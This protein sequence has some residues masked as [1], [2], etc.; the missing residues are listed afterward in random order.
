MEA[1]IVLGNFIIMLLLLRWSRRV[2]RD[3][4]ES[5]K[6]GLFGYREIGR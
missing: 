4:G 1:L 6:S 3:K 2:E 5:A